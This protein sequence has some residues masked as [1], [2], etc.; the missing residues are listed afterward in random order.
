MRSSILRLLEA[1][2]VRLDGA[3]KSREDAR[4]LDWQISAMIRRTAVAVFR[5]FAAAAS[6]GCS[7]PWQIVRQTTP[8]PFLG[9]TQFALLPVNFTGLRVGEKDEVSY[10]ANKD[11][12]SKRKWAGD[13][14]GINS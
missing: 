8:D 2:A 1:A 5:L 11:D 9:K 14:E 10:L 7:P 13:K 12:D 4:P 3:G 6:S